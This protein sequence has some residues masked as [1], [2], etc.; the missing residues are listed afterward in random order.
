MQY[1]DDDD[2][3]ARQKSNKRAD[4]DPNNERNESAGSCRNE[5]DVD[6]YATIGQPG[7][8]SLPLLLLCA[9]LAPH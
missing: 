4:A 3:D 8:T 2:A 7:R 6:A 9:G 5:I 1:N